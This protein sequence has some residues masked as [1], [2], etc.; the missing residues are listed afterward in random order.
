MGMIKEF[1]S[2]VTGK[3]SGPAGAGPSVVVEVLWSTF[4]RAVVLSVIVAV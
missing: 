3:A 1:E 2:A 4:N